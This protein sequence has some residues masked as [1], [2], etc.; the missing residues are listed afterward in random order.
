MREYTYKGIHI[1]ADENL[2]EAVYCEFQ[3]MNLPKESSICILASGPGAFDQR[4]LDEGYTNIVS[5]DIADINIASH[6]N[7]HIR[8]LNKDFDD[9]G[10]FDVVIAMEIIEHIQNTTHFISNV[11]R[12]LKKD[13][14]FLLTTPHLEQL[15]SRFYA[16][17]RNVL[18]MYNPGI[19]RSSGHINPIFHHI[20]EWHLENNK[21]QIQQRSFNREGFSKDDWRSFS[22]VSKLFHILIGTVGKLLP[23][24]DGHISI[25]AIKPIP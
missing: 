2:H 8:D 14:L 18:P 10:S 25:Y 15:S 19:L 3:K 13:G 24:N 22:L 21:L 23:G 12:L 20:L 7:F 17:F 9:L 6:D 5:C 11:K 4:L 16:F 1:S